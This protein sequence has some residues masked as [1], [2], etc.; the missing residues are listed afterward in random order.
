MLHIYL[1]VRWHEESASVQPT[2]GTVEPPRIICRN[3]IFSNAALL[4][5]Q[6]VWTN[7]T[8]M[9]SLNHDS[10]LEKRVV[11]PL[12]TLVYMQR[13]FYANTRDFPSLLC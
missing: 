2:N 9:V 13:C 7:L 12:I 1:A 5:I 4:T 11:A 8:M 10:I 6:V 3:F